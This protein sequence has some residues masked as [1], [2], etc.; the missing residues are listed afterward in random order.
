[1]ELKIKSQVLYDSNNTPVGK[2]YTVNMKAN[3][4]NDKAAVEKYLIDYASKNYE[5]LKSKHVYTHY[6]TDTVGIAVFNN[7]N[8]LDGEEVTIN[9]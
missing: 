4:Y 9:I 8:E 3:N 2:I 7:L 6:Q 5:P 1:M